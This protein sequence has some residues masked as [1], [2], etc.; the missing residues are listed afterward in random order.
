VTR[1]RWWGWGVDGQDGPLPADGDA[2]LTAELG[3]SPERRGHPSLQALEL[4]P[5]GLAPGA[6]AALEAVVG[7][8]WLRD[9]RASRVSHALGRSYPDLVRLRGGTLATA[10]DAVIE[11]STAEEVLGV[12]RACTQ[13]DLAVVPFGGGTSVVGG[14]EAL[15]GDHAGVVALDT[16]RLTGLMDVDARSL[17]ATFRGGTFGPDVEAEL[18]VHGLTLGHLPQSFEFSTLG[19]WVATRSVGQASTDYGRID[20]LVQGLRLTAPAGE[21]ATGAGPPSAAG[22]DLRELLIGSEGTLGVV[23]EAT[24]RVRPRPGATRLEAF[25]LPGFAAGTEALRALAQ[26]GI[27]ATV[28]RLSDEEETRVNLAMADSGRAV[29]ALP[30]YLRARGLDRP[31]LLVL[32]WEGA[33]DA[34]LRARRERGVR[35]L[36][37]HGAVALGRAVGEAWARNRYHGPY[38]RDELLARGVLVDTLE[39][40]A[41]WTGLLETYRAVG[42]A[43]RASL[44]ARGT[45][46]L[47]GCHVSHLYPTGASL[48]FTFLARQEAGAELEQWHA[49]KSAAGDAIVAAGATITHHHGVGR[50]HAPWLHDEVGELGTALLRSAKRTLDPTGIMNP[51]KLLD[52]GPLPGAPA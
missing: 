10:P 2:L 5:P 3:I 46:A 40:A 12:L 13:L 11:P 24:L 38:V 26:G 37:A 43:L 4:P 18:A 49:A 1:Q 17:T 36:R 7:G 29:G 33:D 47:V 19:G 27:A 35:V 48:Y 52:A 41:T 30:G 6:R 51:G 9:D 16:G 15:R 32:G 23:T 14:V 8:A 44:S 45:P 34:S 31:C 25:A 20:D 39:T 21:I 50:D 22:P 28:T 42:A